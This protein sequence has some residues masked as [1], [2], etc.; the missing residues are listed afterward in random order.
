MPRKQKKEDSPILTDDEDFESTLDRRKTV[1]DPYY[2]LSIEKTATAAQIKSG[3][4]RAALRWHPDKATE[5]NKEYANK[6][7]HKI[8]FAYAILSDEKR[9]KR[10]DSTGN[11]SESLEDDDFDWLDFFREQTQARVTVEMAETLKKEYQGSKEEKRDLLDAYE[12]GEGD[13]D[14]IYETIMFS[15]VLVDDER[16]RD[17]IYEALETGKYNYYPAWYKEDGRKTRK[18]RKLARK[19]AR[20]AEAL[21]KELGVQDE[22]LSKGKNGS[23]DDALKAL[24]RTRQRD[25]GSNFL[26]NLE[27]KYGGKRKAEEPPEEMFAENSKKNRK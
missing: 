6:K 24:I 11:K 7:F 20:E 4:R 1:F 26:A 10:Y 19:E 16:F 25:R 5:S 18:R 2:I 27:A 23:G 8:A 15:N 17:T 22:L 14:Y 9:R 21:A 13:L 3:Y 12:V